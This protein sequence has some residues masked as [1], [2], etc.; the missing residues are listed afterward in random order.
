MHVKQSDGTYSLGGVLPLPD[1]GL[2]LYSLTVDIA[3]TKLMTSLTLD[4]HKCAGNASCSANLSA[5]ANGTELHLD[6]VTYLGGVTVLTPFMRSKLTTVDGFTGCL[7]VSRQSPN[8]T[9]PHLH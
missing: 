2:D 4:P 1:P 9:L 6:G 7:G 3:M 8:P 5:P